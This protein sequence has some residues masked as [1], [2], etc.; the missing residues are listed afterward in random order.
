MVDIVTVGHI[1]NEKIIFPDREIYPVLGSPVA[2]SSVCMASLG[3]KVG[4]VTNIGKDFPQSLFD[5][6]NEVGVDKDGVKIGRYSTNN[7]LIYDQCGHK[8]LKY[9]SKADD[10]QFVDIPRSYNNAK[11]YYICPMDY[12][13]P[14]ETIKKISRNKK[15]IVIDLGGYGGG[16]SETHPE[17]K[18][19][20]EIK[21]LCSYSQIVKASIEDYNHI[22]GIR[23]G[24]EKKIGKKILNWGA[25]VCIITMGEKGSFVKTRDKEKYILP[26]PLKR[27]VDQTG[28]GD[29]YSAGFLAHFLEDND[30]Y[31]SAVYA[32]ATASYIIAGSGGV[33]SERMPDKM[34]VEKRV[35]VIKNLMCQY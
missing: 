29:C 35:K 21:E 3:V 33:I 11:I 2:Y 32:T 20:N 10:I 9:L 30:P 17:E 15:K 24:D 5:V 7:E 8:I 6:F 14:S 13:V 12:E 19:G 27:I 28:A 4:I 1:L 25:E 34:E 16:T 26:Y 23:I 31:V 18:D 22:F